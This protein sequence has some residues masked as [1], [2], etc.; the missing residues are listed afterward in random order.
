MLKKPQQ[1]LGAFDAAVQRDPTY[2]PADLRAG[3]LLVRLGRFR[4]ARARLERALE[5]THWRLPEGIYYLALAHRGLGSPGPERRARAALRQ[6][7][8]ALAAVYPRLLDIK[9]P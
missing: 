6:A 7:A 3:E 1:A 9:K 8:P 5:T 2:W 4:E